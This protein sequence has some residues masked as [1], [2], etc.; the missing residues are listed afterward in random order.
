MT[1][2]LIVMTTALCAFMAIRA[3][4]LIMA[5]LWLAGASALVSIA[6]YAAGAHIAAVIELSVGAGLVTVLFVFAI[7]IAGDDAL[8]SREFIPNPVAIVLALVFLV[9]LSWM[10]LPIDTTEAVLDKVPFADVMWH[11]RIVDT[12][13]QLVLI[14]TGVLCLLG[15]MTEEKSPGPPQIAEIGQPQTL[16]VLSS[17]GRFMPPVEPVSPETEREEVIA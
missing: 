12:L 17:G 3:R 11:D 14:F 13:L 8:R 9:L 2:L 4:H 1:Y 6:L 16:A 7:S 5:A 10:V 15:L